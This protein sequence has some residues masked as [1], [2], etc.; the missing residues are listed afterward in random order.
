MKT[1][2]QLYFIALCAAF[3]T[4]CCKDPFAQTETGVGTLGCIINGEPYWSQAYR[5]PGIKDM[6]IHY[7][8]NPTDGYDYT[9]ILRANCH[10]RSDKKEGGGELFIYIKSPELILTGEK[11][12]F[13][14]D[15][16]NYSTYASWN[17]NAAY[18]GYVIFRKLER[19]KTETG[20]EVVIAGNFEF[21]AQSEP[22]NPGETPV[23]YV[24]TEGTVDTTCET[25]VL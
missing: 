21:V 25:D 20:S 9:L 17:D 18:S 3:F 7:N 13:A 23:K 2:R 22:E 8:H 15:D 19:V 1:L 16:P 11:Y 6:K 4:G 24:C 12:Y 10:H 5:F 14:G